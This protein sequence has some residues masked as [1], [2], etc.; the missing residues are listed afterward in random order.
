MHEY[1]D[2]GRLVRTVV[3]REP[4]Y[5]DVQRDWLNALAEYE[6]G[7]DENGFPVEE[8]TSPL[9]DPDNPK[10]THFYEVEVRRNWA[11][12]AVEQEQKKPE[13]SGENYLRAR[14]FVPV[15]R[16]LPTLG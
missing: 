7:L 9:A 16:D 15:R 13:W 10:R 12:F 4:E 2:D 8:S 14:K 11:T 6:E 5:D 3:T 1:D